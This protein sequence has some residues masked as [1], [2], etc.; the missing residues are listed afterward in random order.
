VN[1]PR[2]QLLAGARFADQQNGR[3]ARG[4][5]TTREVYRIPNGPAVPDDVLEPKIGGL[6]R[7]RDEAGIGID[8]LLSRVLSVMKK[9]LG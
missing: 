2:K 9:T 5:D 4:G 8:H 7:I 6:S 3:P 1:A